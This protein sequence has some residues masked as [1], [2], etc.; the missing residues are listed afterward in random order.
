MKKLL[1]LLPVSLLLCSCKGIGVIFYV[2]SKTETGK[3][4]FPPLIIPFI[5]PLVILYELFTTVL[6][7]FLALAI[8]LPSKRD[9]DF[10]GFGVFAFI[11]GVLSFITYFTSDDITALISLA[12]LAG[13]PLVTRKVYGV[14]WGRAFGTLG[15][16]ILF[17][18]ITELI[19]N[20]I[21]AL[22]QFL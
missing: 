17:M 1:Y 19:V 22:R 5:L 4:F 15:L 14:S 8:Q 21:L 3:D 6:P 16:F 13:I 12:V 11:V 2:I 20:A 18:F 9:E 10:E 7:L